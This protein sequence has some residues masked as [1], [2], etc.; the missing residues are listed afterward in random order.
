MLWSQNQ[1]DRP[2]VVAMATTFLEGALKKSAKNIRKKSF[3]FSKH[4]F[5]E[6]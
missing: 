2:T 4:I 3:F 1:K 5:I 6:I